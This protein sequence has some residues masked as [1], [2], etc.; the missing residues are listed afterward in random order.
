MTGLTSLGA[1][2]SERNTPPR[3]TPGHRPASIR[4][5]ISFQNAK[6]P[7]SP[8][9]GAT[10]S[11]RSHRGFHIPRRPVL[12]KNAKRPWFGKF[13]NS[14]SPIHPIPIR[15]GMNGDHTLLDRPMRL[16][17]LSAD[18]GNRE[19]IDPVATPL[20]QWLQ[21]SRLDG[22]SGRPVGFASLKTRGTERNENSR[23]RRGS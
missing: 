16:R 9:N 19:R 23:P 11:M 14:G 22:F 17:L 10:F 6:D 5:P 4:C 13:S 3:S 8:P 12:N 2:T 7:S 15:Q 21:Y 18:E 1:V 20:G